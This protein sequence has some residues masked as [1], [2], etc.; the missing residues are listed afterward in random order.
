MRYTSMRKRVRGLE[1]ERDMTSLDAQLRQSILQRSRELRVYP[2][3]IDLGGMP[4]T[5]EELVELA[6]KCDQRATNIDRYISKTRISEKPHKV[7]C[8]L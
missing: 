2:E 3:V 7:R 5:S 4:T 6:G 8:I 1:T